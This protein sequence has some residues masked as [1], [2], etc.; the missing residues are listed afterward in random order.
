[1]I[2]TLAVS[3]VSALSFL[4]GYLWGR[5]SPSQ[6]SRYQWKT[7]PRDLS[8]L[9][10]Y[11]RPNPLNQP[12]LPDH[13]QDQWD[14]IKYQ[15]NSLPANSA[16]SYDLPGGPRASGNKPPAWSSANPTGTP[17]QSVTLGGVSVSSKLES[18]G[19]AGKGGS[20]TL[21][22]RNRVTTIPFTTP[23]S[24]TSS[25]NEADGAPGVASPEGL[26]R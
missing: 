21:D 24:P 19:P 8:A 16:M 18:P 14:W 26:E 10:L 20:S 3:A 7:R 6:L 9:N 2:T 25:G 11:Q 23:P 13:H 5:M 4:A 22:S 17:I 15:P 1:M 12:P